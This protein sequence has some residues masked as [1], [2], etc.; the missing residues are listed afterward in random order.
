MLTMTKSY[1]VA[2]FTY[3]S[4]VPSVGATLAPESFAAERELAAVN[5]ASPATPNGT[6]NSV[7]QL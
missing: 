7:R 3:I 2:T 4:I 1:T 6:C 5:A